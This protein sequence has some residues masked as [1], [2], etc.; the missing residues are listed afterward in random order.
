MSR[1]TL[2]AHYAVL[3][4]QWA[5]RGIDLDA[6]YMGVRDWI[7]PAVAE[8]LREYAELDPDSL[9][10]GLL[11]SDPAPE[12]FRIDR[13]TGVVG[14]ID[15]G[16]A[17]S[18]PLLYDVASTVMYVGGLDRA[19]V[20]LDAY[21]ASGSLPSAEVERGVST[22]LKFRWAIQA[23]YFAW[24]IANDDLTGIDDPAGNEV[25]LA[26]AKRMLS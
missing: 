5:E 19:G 10:S 4:E 17:L 7:R 21:V 6:D 16:A 20:L 3:K 2:E 22:M 12:A 9:T 1:K 14:L 18:G 13:S 15:W 25:G 23:M 11:H 24:R 8:V 26:D